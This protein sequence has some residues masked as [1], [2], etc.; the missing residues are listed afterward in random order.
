ML[1]L[2]LR[3][4]FPGQLLLLSTLL[5]HSFDDLLLLSLLFLTLSYNTSI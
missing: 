3:R 5:L 4:N 2:L 1:Q